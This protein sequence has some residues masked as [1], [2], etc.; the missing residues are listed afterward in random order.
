MVCKRKGIECQYVD[1]QKGTCNT[2]CF[3][4][5]PDIDVKNKNKLK[6]GWMEAK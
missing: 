2:Y 6:N 5:Y 1:P 4:N 3:Y